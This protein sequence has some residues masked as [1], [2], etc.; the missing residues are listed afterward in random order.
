M[1]DRIQELFTYN[2]KSFFVSLLEKMVLL[3][4]DEKVDIKVS[5]HDAFLK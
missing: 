1:C 5:G 2:E 3:V 4:H